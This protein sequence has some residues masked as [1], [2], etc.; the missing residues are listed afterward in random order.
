MVKIPTFHYYLFYNI[1]Y[2]KK[3]YLEYIREHCR[4]FTI[5]KNLPIISTSKS[6]RFPSSVGII[7][8]NLLCSGQ[9]KLYSEKL[10]IPFYIIFLQSP[11]SVIN[12]PKF[13]FSR[14]LRVPISVGILPPSWLLSISK[15]TRKTL[16]KDRKDK[17]YLKIEIISCLPRKITLTFFI[18][19]I[20][21]LIDPVTALLPVR[22][23]FFFTLVSW[24]QK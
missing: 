15:S 6:S 14:E 10:G 13:N 1:K 8:F 21:A 18:F 22:I 5:K 12:S 24:R 16:A 23:I 9:Y 2:I 17:K 19:S 4:R 20:C 11:H 7:E 3:Y